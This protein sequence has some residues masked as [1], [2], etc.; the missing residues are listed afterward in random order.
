MARKTEIERK[1]EVP[2]D[3]AVPDLTGIPGV[4]VVDE[5]AEHR[6]DAV[7]YDTPGLLLAAERVTLRRRT[8]GH[9]A[10]WHLKRPATGGDRTELHLPLDGHGREV[11]PAVQDEVRALSRGEPLVP[12]ARIRTRRRERPLRAADGTVLALIADDLVTSEPVGRTA[13][14]Q[15]WREVEVELADGGRDVLDAV[16][17]VLRSAGA[18]PARSPSKLARALSGP[19]GAPSETPDR[20]EVLDRPEASGTAEPSGPVGSGARALNAYLRRQYDA[21]L[22]TDEAVRRGDP[23]AVHDMRVAIRRLRSTLRTFRP[24]FDPVHAG[25][26][27]DELRWLGGLLGD[28]RDGDVVDGRLA[29]AVAAE[30][31]ELVAGPVA[32]R[33]HGRLAARTADART[34]LADALGGPRYAALLDTLNGLA[35]TAPPGRVPRKRLRRR[36]RKAVRRADRYLDTALAAA[37]TAATGTP[38]TAATGTPVTADATAAADTATGGDRETRLHDARRAYKRARYAVE[39]LAPLSGRPAR[40]LAD[41]L[42]VLQDLLGGYRDTVASMELLR[43]YG[44]RAHLDGENAFTYGLLYAREQ[45]VGERRLE[46]LGDARARARRPKVRRWLE[47]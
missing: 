5:P 24:L 6:L 13:P 41:R 26:L 32:A 18:L 27:R 3:F 16:D 9:D 36:A 30:P 42:T 4:I 35:E 15:R 7:Y 31:P 11:P 1:Y 8:G 47:S 2:A 22:D 28:V 14:A 21:I 34:R 23:E 43:E 19:T 39:V 40:R 46:R 25:R 38:D 29:V 45:A 37:D 44:M 33:I 10:G 20:P 17:E 12:V